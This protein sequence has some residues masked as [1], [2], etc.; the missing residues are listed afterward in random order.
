MV[1]HSLRTPPIQV[2]R[3]LHGPPGAW[4]QVKIATPV[5][6]PLLGGGMSDSAGGWNEWQCWWGGMSG[7][8]AGGGMTG[9]AAGGMG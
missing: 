4:G 6:T 1:G 3:E 7:S 2:Y 8:A 5:C 9:S